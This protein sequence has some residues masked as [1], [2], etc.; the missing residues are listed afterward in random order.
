MSPAVRVLHIADIVEVHDRI[1]G[2]RAA[3]D[4]VTE[5]AGGAFDPRLVQCLVA[6][7]AEILAGL[8]E[9]SWDEVIATDPAMGAPMA[10]DELDDALAVLGDYA[11]LFL[12]SRGT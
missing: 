6:N 11:D 8:D 3:L 4:V 9:S 2:A 7:H 5:R 10:E 12:K 1:G